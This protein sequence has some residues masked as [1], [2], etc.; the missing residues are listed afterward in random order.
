[1]NQLKDKAGLETDCNR[2]SH[3]FTPHFKE[4]FEI[5]KA[6][7]QDGCDTS[8][9]DVRTCSELQTRIHES[10]MRK[11][12]RNFAMY[13]SEKALHTM[14][15]LASLTKYCEAQHFPPMHQVYLKL[16]TYLQIIETGIV[17]RLVMNALRVALGK[18]PNQDLFVKSPLG[19]H[20]FEV[21]NRYYTNNKDENCPLSLFT[22]W[23]GLMNRTLRNAIAHND[24]WIDSDSRAVELL[25]NTIERNMLRHRATG[26]LP[27]RI[28]F[29]DVDL[30]LQ[31]FCCVCRA[32]Q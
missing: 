27:E 26:N 16:F 23:D 15:N 31:T 10:G 14:T 9:Y 21:I 7:S 2:D 19:C 20:K 28:S 22:H 29:A 12:P 4:L 11:L 30:L 24:F 5:A 25:S 1:M 6:R 17:D 3:M 32:F 18:K 8:F 13:G